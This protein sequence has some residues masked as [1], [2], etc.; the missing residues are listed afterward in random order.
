MRPMATELPLTGGC[1]CGAVRFE[2][3][4]PLVAASY[5]HCTRCQRRTGTAASAK[6]RD[7]ARLVH[8]ALGRRPA[9]QLEPRAGLRQGLLHELRRGAVQP[10]PGRPEV[11]SIRLGA[12][13]RDPGIRPQYRQ[14]VAYAA[15]WEPIPEDGLPR[16]AERTSELAVPSRARLS[17]SRSVARSL[18]LSAPSTSPSIVCCA[19][20]A[21]SSAL[22]PGL[23]QLDDV[24]AA[25]G[26]IALARREAR[27]LELVQQ[28][29]AVVRIQVHRLAERLLR[30]LRVVPQ[31]R[32][33]HQLLEA[34]AEQ[35]LGAAAIHEPREAREQ[36]DRARCGRRS[37][38]A[39]ILAPA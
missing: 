9:R 38:R 8:A 21:C 28:Q 13:D 26:R 37:H 30:G 20:S 27:P 1:N 33:R 25:V 23:R 32:E 19:C 11:V 31:V 7:R 29:D 17:R 2:V 12:F 18:A 24:T 14:F 5:C 35:L 4:E 3:S 6:A 39:A 10:E 16:H 22:P 36:H 34:D 15:P